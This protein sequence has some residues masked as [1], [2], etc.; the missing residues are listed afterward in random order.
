MNQVV[1]SLHDNAQTLQQFNQSQLQP[2]IMSVT[3]C[4]AETAMSS[5]QY[6]CNMLSKFLCLHASGI[7][8][9]G[10]LEFFKKAY[11]AG[12]C[13]PHGY[14]GTPVT[15]FFKTMGINATVM[16]YQTKPEAQPGDCF[17][18]SINGGHHF[19]SVGVD[20]DNNMYLFD[21][22]NTIYRPYG[23]ELDMALAV[24]GDKI[25]WFKKYA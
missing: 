3:G 21:T 5:G 24:H 16:E 13:T 7:W 12:L 20:D 1:Q 25:D 14:I 19:M 6:H 2:I 15:D 18:I 17:Q 10:Y 4:D 11:E 22:H 9:Q 8:Q 23:G